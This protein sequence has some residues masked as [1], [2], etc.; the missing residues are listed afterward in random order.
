[1]TDLSAVGRD[2]AALSDAHER[3][4]A[5]LED[6]A[7]TL[8]GNQASSAAAARKDLLDALM[9]S[10]LAF[11]D[12]IDPRPLG[13]GEAYSGALQSTDALG[14]ESFDCYCRTHGRFAGKPVEVIELTRLLGGFSKDTFIATLAGSDR[15]ADQIVIRRDA[16]SGPI[17]ASVTDEYPLIAGLLRAG[18]PVAEPFWVEPDAS[19]FGSPF[20]VAR[21]MPGAV[22]LHSD[23]VTLLVGREEGAN[24]ARKLAVLL[25][26][27]HTTDLT[28]LGYSKQVAATPAAEHLV[29][30]VDEFERYWDTRKSAP[31]PIMAAAFGWLR[32]NVPAVVPGPA[33]VHGDASLRNILMHEGEIAA[34]LDWETAHIGDPSEDISYARRDIELVMPWSE[35]LEIYRDAGG[36]EY[37]EENARYF[38]LWAD[39]RNGAYSLAHGFET[40][41]IPD[42]RFAFSSS[43]YHRGFLRS[44]AAFLKRHA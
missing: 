31:E 40:A 44:I 23:G 27:L 25:A 34:L 4:S 11:L 5:A 33:I 17:D 22:P 6:V 16:P 42:I 32:R 14:A 24:A 18:L 29:K 37:R 10:E 9:D 13:P 35:F 8:I 38:Q 30:L 12:A 1:V 20:M 19:I 2:R 7:R 26:R 15:P 28:S 21:R 43:Y 3:A 41:P 39:V 36:P